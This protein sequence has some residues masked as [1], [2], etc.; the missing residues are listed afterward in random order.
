MKEK[1]RSR[2]AR[3]RAL[4]RATKASGKALQL[5]ISIAIF[6]M[7]SNEKPCDASE[8]FAQV[9]AFRGRRAPCAIWHLRGSDYASSRATPTALHTFSILV[10]TRCCSTKFNLPSAEEQVCGKSAAPP[11]PTRAT[12]ESCQP[13]SNSNTLDPLAA[14]HKRV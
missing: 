12:L 1:Y 9:L 5:C 6:Y 11:I 14:T 7:R 3:T 10:S 8:C 2:P 13:C 4:S